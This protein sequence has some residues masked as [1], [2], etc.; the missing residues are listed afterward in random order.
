[1]IHSRRIIIF[2][3]ILYGALC[4]TP[5]KRPTSSPTSKPSKAPTPVPTHVPTSDIQ[6]YFHLDTYEDWIAGDSIM[7]GHYQRLNKVNLVDDDVFKSYIPWSNF[8]FMNN[9]YDMIYV[10][11]NGIVSFARSEYSYYGA[12]SERKTTPNERKSN[13]DKVSD[14]KVKSSPPVKVGQSPKTEDHKNKKTEMHKNVKGVPSSSLDFSSFKDMKSKSA[15]DLSTDVI[16][17]LSRDSH[18]KHFNQL[19]KDINTMHHDHSKPLFHGKIEK[20]YDSLKA[21]RVSKP[22]SNTLNVHQRK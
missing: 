13:N 3:S 21:F 17:A 4:A 12:Y 8:K 5:T 2:L 6:R 18:V 22:S 9:S 10:S 19:I 15:I 7:N 20:Q 16:V 11:S 1:M 14:A